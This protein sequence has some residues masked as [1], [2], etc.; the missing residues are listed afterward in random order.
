VTTSDRG[1]TT[2][3]RRKR[4]DNVSWT[5]MNLTGS[6]IEKIHVVNLAGT[7]EQWRFKATIS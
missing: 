4:G 1:E 3:G 7:N 5:D 2:L 6:K